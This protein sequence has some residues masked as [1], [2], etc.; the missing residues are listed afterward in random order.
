[1]D[2]APLDRKNVFGMFLKNYEDK[3]EQLK[4]V[5]KET[6]ELKKNLENGGKDNEIEEQFVIVN[7]NPFDKD[8]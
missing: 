4:Q 5:L 2:L 8:F 1:M 6:Q 7:E 3:A